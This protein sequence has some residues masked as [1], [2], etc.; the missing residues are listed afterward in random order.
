MKRIP[1]I[2]LLLNLAAELQF[3]YNADA[4]PLIYLNLFFCIGLGV[5]IGFR[6]DAAGYVE[7]QNDG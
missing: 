5:V 7:K 4:S 1:E 2:L 6:L 3:L